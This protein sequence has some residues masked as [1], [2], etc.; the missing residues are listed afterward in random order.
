LI[1]ENLSWAEFVEQ[2]TGMSKSTVYRYREMA[3]A[4]AKKVKS[5]GNLIDAAPGEITAEDRERIARA[6]H[7]VTDGHT[8]TE[9]FREWGLAKLDPSKEALKARAIAKENPEPPADEDKAWA[10]MQQQTKADLAASDFLEWSTNTTAYFLKRRQWMHLSDEALAEAK[11][12]IRAIAAG[13]R[14]ALERLVDLAAPRLAIT[15]DTAERRRILAKEIASLRREIK[16]E[17]P[18]AMRRL[19]Q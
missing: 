10:E 19:S 5:L 17:F 18:R 15:G 16:R 7:K 1:P 9:L 2:H 3:A 6:V 8:A 11:T 4:A 13:L 14:G 12:L